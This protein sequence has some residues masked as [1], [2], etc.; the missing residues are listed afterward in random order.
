MCDSIEFRW[1]PPWP[2]TS[3]SGGFPSLP[4]ADAPAAGVFS[5]VPPSKIR[6][7]ASVDASEGHG[8]RKARIG[9]CAGPPR[10]LAAQGSVRDLKSLEIQYRDYELGMEHSHESVRQLAITYRGLLSDC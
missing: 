5:S 7:S 1:L 10:S 6:V 9:S 2:P 8:C 4:S 3:P